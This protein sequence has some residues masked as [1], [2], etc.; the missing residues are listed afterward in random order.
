MKSNATAGLA[1]ILILGC[2]TSQLHQRPNLAYQ[3]PDDEPSLETLQR[4]HRVMESYTAAID[5]QIA[6]ARRKGS[7][8]ATFTFK[9]T[10]YVREGNAFGNDFLILV[11]LL[12]RHYDGHGYRVT[13]GY[14]AGVIGIIFEW[15]PSSETTT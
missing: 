10:S 15:S 2:G 4:F 8:T 11:H 12:E 3:R 14:G 9:D 6:E 1:L 7:T 13:I 5:G